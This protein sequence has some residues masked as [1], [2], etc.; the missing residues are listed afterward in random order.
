MLRRRH[1][2]E[3]RD[4]RWVDMLPYSSAEH[5]VNLAHGGGE[6][7]SEVG[8]ILLSI[9]RGEGLADPSKLGNVL[10]LRVR[11]VERELQS[12][13]IDCS[14]EVGFR[15]RDSANAGIYPFVESLPQSLILQYSSPTNHQPEFSINLDIYEMLMR[16]NSGYRPTIEELQGIYRILLVFKNILS[17]APYQEVLTHRNGPRVLPDFRDDDGILQLST[18]ESEIN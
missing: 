11:Q 6:L 9:N 2:F 3:R 14:K 8:S 1:Y 7:A 12:G 13:A 4:Q 15:S 16:L 10:A 17:S 5:F 18:V